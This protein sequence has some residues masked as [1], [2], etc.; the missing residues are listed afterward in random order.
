MA[1]M[2][3]LAMSIIIIKYQHEPNNLI[4]KWYQHPSKKITKGFCFLKKP[5]YSLDR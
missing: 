5:Q 1:H 3:I 4:S 2:L